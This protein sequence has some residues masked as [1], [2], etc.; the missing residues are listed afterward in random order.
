MPRIALRFFA[1]FLL[2]GLFWTLL[3]RLGTGEWRW[4][5]FLGF[6]AVGVGLG[7]MSLASPRFARGA[8]WV[9]ARLVSWLELA[10]SFVALAVVF[11]LVV[12][13]LGWLLRLTGRVGMRGKFLDK[14]TP[15]FWKPL[16]YAREPR[17]YFRQF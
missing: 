2:T 15:S 11:F 4:M 6:A 16:R 1:G 13:P 12:T 3:V 5:V 14:A 7:S 17:S 9:W 10:L 8:E